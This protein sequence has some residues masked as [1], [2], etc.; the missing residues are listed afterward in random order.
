LK[1]SFSKLTATE[2][3]ELVWYFSKAEND[4]GPLINACR[5]FDKLVREILTKEKLFL[6]SSSL[7]G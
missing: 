2:I 6:K 1:S 5:L 7:I 4:S 3:S